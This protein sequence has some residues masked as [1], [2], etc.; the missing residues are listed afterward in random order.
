MEGTFR[1]MDEKWRREAHSRMKHLAQAIAD[2]M[3]ASCEFEIVEGYP[4]LH[5]DPGITAK[6][7]EFARSYLGK[8]HIDELDIRMTAEDFA[9]F[10]QEYPSVLYRLGVRKS[11]QVLPCELHSP[12][13]NIDEEAIRTGSGLMAWLALSHLKVD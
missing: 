2:S 5:N 11:E 13:F 1:T 9:F 10:A 8:D 7:I 6:S 3:G 4:V 12:H